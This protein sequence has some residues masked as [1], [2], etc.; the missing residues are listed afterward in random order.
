MVVRAAQEAHLRAFQ[1]GSPRL[2]P[3]PR[4]KEDRCDSG[5]CAPR[6][7]IYEQVSDISIHDRLQMFAQRINGPTALILRWINRWPPRLDK[8]DEA[9]F[10]PVR[11][12]VV[13]PECG[14]CLKFS[15]P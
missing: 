7:K 10:K 8:V 13:A 14:R 2:R 3:H 12:L 6:W 9:S 5:L 1:E 4:R 11:L 15:A